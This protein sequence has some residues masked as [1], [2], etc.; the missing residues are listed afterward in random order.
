M[1]EGPSSYTLRGL[2][3]PHDCH[4]PTRLAM[5]TFLWPQLVATGAQDLDSPGRG[6]APTP[7]LGPL[8]FQ[9]SQL[10]VLMD[11]LF[12]QVVIKTQ[13]EYE[14]SSMDQPKKFSDLEAQK[15]AC[16]HPEEGRRVTQ[17]SWFS[18]AGGQSP[19]E[20]GKLDWGGCHSE[21][22]RVPWGGGA[23]LRDL[24]L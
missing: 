11:H 13:T 1:G 14:L 15:L 8:P 7:L 3:R 5:S 20:S 23:W 19:G 24:G 2:A 16:G 17:S 21:A 10:M 18:A 4:V 6:S 12:E 22:G 9:P